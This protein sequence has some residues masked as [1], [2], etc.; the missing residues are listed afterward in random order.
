M[1]VIEY[2]NISTVHYLAQFI[3]MGTVAGLEEFQQGSICGH[4]WNLL[5]HESMDLSHS[6]QKPHMV[7]SNP[8]PK[9]LH[10]ATTHTGPDSG[11]FQLLSLLVLCTFWRCCSRL[12]ATRVIHGSSIH[13]LEPFL[14][15]VLCFWHRL[16][17]V[18]VY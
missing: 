8:L 10:N 16:H 17:N 12:Y 15:L 7:L 13:S 1:S 3:D 2:S 14:Y 5:F 11:C 4:V 18:P 6:M 9:S